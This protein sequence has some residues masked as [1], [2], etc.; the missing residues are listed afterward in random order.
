MIDTDLDL[1]RLQAE[2][3][4][5]HDANG[6]LVCINEPDPTNPAPRFFLARTKVGHLWRARFDL[7][8]DLAAELDRLAA[9]EPVVSDLSE[10][11]HYAVQY[12]ALLNQHSPLVATDA[13]PAYYL[14]EPDQLDQPH[15]AVLITPE[16]INLLQA[17]FSWLLTTLTDYAPVAAA[18]VDGQAV[19]VCF[20]SRI[21]TKVCEA[22]VHTEEKYRGHGYATQAA[23]GWA[24]AVRST[25]RLPFYST[26]WS[27]LASQAIARKLGGVLYGVDFSAT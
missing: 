10:Q 2:A 24:K 20:C 21:T 7:P 4:F 1:M 26:S 14:P 11:P 13:G 17:H 22:G 3:L 5:V 19:A 16:N 6:R 27:N 15:N 18:I 25:G 8:L 9:A 12:A 23:R